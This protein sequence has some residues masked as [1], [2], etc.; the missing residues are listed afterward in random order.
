MVGAQHRVLKLLTE[1]LRAWE[2]DIPAAILGFVAGHGN[3]GTFRAVYD[4]KSPNGKV[5]AQ[6]D[7]DVCQNIAAGIDGVDFHIQLQ[8]SG[9]LCGCRSRSGFGSC[10]A[11]RDISLAAPPANGALVCRIAAFIELSAL[12]PDA[13]FAVLLMVVKALQIF[14]KVKASGFP[15][16]VPAVLLRGLNAGD[17][18]KSRTHSQVTN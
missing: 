17:E 14:V 16:D 6:G 1:L 15:D 2:A 13:L 11:L 5:A 9:F 4:P 18:V 8:G 10:F 7:G 12:L 3:K